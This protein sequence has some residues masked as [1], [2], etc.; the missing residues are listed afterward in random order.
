MVAGGERWE[1]LTSPFLSILHSFALYMCLY[2]NS[3]IY[4]F[5]EFYISHVLILWLG[6]IIHFFQL[7]TCINLAQ[8][9]PHLFSTLS[10]RPLPPPKPSVCFKLLSYLS[11]SPCF[12]YALRTQLVSTQSWKAL[13]VKE[14]TEG[15]GV[16]VRGR[17][18]G[19]ECGAGRSV[20]CSATSDH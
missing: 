8:R 13:E 14:E 18:G 16:E 20:R 11:P 5:Y 4:F 6:L 15:R 19:S 7:A 10:H 1:L 17:G 3:F 9:F 12:L 2:P